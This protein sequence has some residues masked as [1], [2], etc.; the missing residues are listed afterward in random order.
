[1]GA[2]GRAYALDIVVWR[3]HSVRVTRN[4]PKLKGAQTF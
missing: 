3:A 2:D 1:M 4:A